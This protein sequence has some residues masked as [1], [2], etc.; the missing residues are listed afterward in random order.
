[1][2]NQRM[3]RLRANPCS[4]ELIRETHLN[5]SDLIYPLFVVEGEGVKKE[6][7][8]IPGCFHFSLDM[9]QGE[10]EEIY[11]LGLRYVL[12]FGI[13]ASKDHCGS[14]AFQK[15]GIVQRAIKTIKELCPEIYV[16]TDVCLCEYTSHGHCGLVDENGF[17]KNDETVETL[18]K[19]AFSH[20]EAGA[21]MVAPSDMMDFRVSAIREHLDRNNYSH[22]PIMAYSAKY[23]SSYYG[24]F[25]EAV[26][27]SPKFSNRKSYQMDY[28]NSDEALREMRLDVEEGADIIMVKPALS[29]LDI[30]RRGRDTFNIPMAAY[31]VSGEYV[32]L[33]MAVD[34][35][36]IDE[37]AIIE[38]LVSI[39]RAG[40]DIII[41]Y[42]AKEI[43]KLL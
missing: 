29:Y 19:V 38:S 5:K 26:N 24:P 4:R 27:S 14:M 39:K 2:R 17:I 41:T 25:R 20:V 7:P 13:P 23:A 36:L 21:D 40:A 9:L 10:M 22:I 35:G 18:S 15:D 43:A 12:L 31:Q 42:F 33:K 11:K 37:E 28:A 32:M 8:T 3:R 6:I 30:I 1:M 16:I 34:N